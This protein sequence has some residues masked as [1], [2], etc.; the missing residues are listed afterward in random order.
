LP[1]TAQE[2]AHDMK[3]LRIVGCQQSLW[4]IVSVGND[5]TL[6]PSNTSKME[7]RVEGC[8]ADEDGAWLLKYV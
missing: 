5:E 4:E 3:H 7:W 2:L 6:L 1:V 8:F